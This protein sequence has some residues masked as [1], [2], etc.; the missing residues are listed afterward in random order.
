MDKPQTLL[1]FLHAESSSDSIDSM[2]NKVKFNKPP[3]VEVVCGVAFQSLDAMRVVH[4]GEFLKLL[5][6]EF[7]RLED[8]L[9]IVTP[10]AESVI[11]W[12]SVP[13]LPRVW[14]LTGNEEKLVQVQR[15]RFLY[16]WKCLDQNKT[17]P[18][19][20]RIFPE[21]LERYQDFVGFVS[22]HDLGKIDIRQFELT[23]VNHIYKSQLDGAVDQLR[24]VLR[25]VGP[26]SSSGKFLPLPS[27]FRS[28]ETYDLPEDNGKL[29]VTAQSARKTDG[30]DD[31]ELLR[32]DLTVRGIGAGT[33]LEQMK[34]WF[35]LAHDWI[36]NGF[37]DV[38]NPKIQ[39][40]IWE[41]E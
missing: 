15:D 20:T 34:S 38:T 21:F 9:P 1:K 29:H 12:S 5:P 40:S 35:G 14:Y 22:S 13:P 2:D 10:G 25:Q 7:E 32:L 4:L 11:D 18:E 28:T 17:Y 31:G 24:E 3:V 33:S 30:S 8:M 36:V 37:V 23:Y 41:K 27:A 26:A 19:F 39:S 6:G 16:N